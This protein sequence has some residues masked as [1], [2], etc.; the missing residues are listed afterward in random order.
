MKRIEFNKCEHCPHCVIA[1]GD[2]FRKNGLYISLFCS[3]QMKPIF[4]ENIPLWCLLPDSP[5]LIKEEQK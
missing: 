5:K 1:K 3:N 2:K 4:E